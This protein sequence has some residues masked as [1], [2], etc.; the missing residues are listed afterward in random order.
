MI[1]NHNH[2]IKLKITIAKNL[3][4]YYTKSK[5]DVERYHQKGI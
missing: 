4:L 1:T 5:N 2:F 3:E